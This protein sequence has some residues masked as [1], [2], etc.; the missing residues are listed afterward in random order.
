MSL[1]SV[2]EQQIRSTTGNAFHCRQRAPV[3]GGCIHSTWQ[4]DDGSTRYF[5]KTNQAARLPLFESEA[6]GLV[7]LAASAALRVPA[8]LCYGTAGSEAYLV[9]EWLDLQ[10]HGDA[11]HLG[12]QLAA[13]HRHT[14]RQFGFDRDNHIGDIPQHNAWCDDWIAFWRDQRL[15]FQLEL[16]AKNGMQGTL[17]I[18]GERLM[19]RLPGLFEGYQPL[20]S[21]L[22]G[23][24]WRGNVG[25]MHDGTPA[26]FDPACYYGD[27]EA[28]LAMSE[29]FGGFPAD[30]YA[31][32]QAAWPL[33][34]GYAQRKQLY[35]LYHVLNHANLFGGGY[36][37][38]AGEMMR[39]LLA[40]LG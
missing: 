24:L 15:G 5:V 36:A 2:I 14:A 28:D 22:H 35:N 40:T 37:R 33:D 4:I 20:P 39:A 23:D 16:A 25:F 27:R 3:S 38:Q 12:Q 13:L 11:V 18:H 26:I 9:L 21:L 30:F 10:D 1:W 32:Y 19:A 6:A 8:P 31:A 29:L 7:A 34:A 17:Q